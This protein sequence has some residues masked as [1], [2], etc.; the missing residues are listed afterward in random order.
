M[1]QVRMTAASGAIT[2]WAMSRRQRGGGSLLERTPTAMTGVRLVDSR[3][4]VEGT[5]VASRAEAHTRTTEGAALSQDQTESIVL[6]DRRSARERGAAL[7]SSFSPPRA[8]GLC[9]GRA[10]V[11]RSVPPPRRGGRF[12]APRNLK[13]R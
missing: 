3:Q 10:F 6:R 4:G 9:A 5:R 8:V 13:R 2:C 1:P 7:S 11:R 12:C